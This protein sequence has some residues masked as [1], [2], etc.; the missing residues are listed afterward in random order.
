MSK[1]FRNFSAALFVIIT[2]GVIFALAGN[3]SESI[4]NESVLYDDI[5]AIERW[6][7]YGILPRVGAHNFDRN[8]TYYGF[9]DIMRRLLAYQIDEK[10][11][12]NSGLLYIRY[13][14]A[15]EIL[16]GAMGRDFNL[17]HNPLHFLSFRQ[18][19][20]ML[21]DMVQ[22]FKTN[23]FNLNLADI[24]LEN[25]LVIN[26]LHS[27]PYVL[28]SVLAN[29]S[30]SGD[31]VIVPRY[32]SHI[33][34]SNIGIEGNIV[35]IRGEYGPLSISLHNSAANALY[36][37]A[38]AEITLMGSNQIENIKVFAPADIDS[39]ALARGAILPNIYINIADAKLSGRFN[40]VEIN[41]DH[42]YAPI[43]LSA[44]GHIENLRS[45]GE[46]ILIGDV[47]VAAYNAPSLN[48]INSYGFYR[49]AE[50]SQAVE[51][52]VETA[53]SYF[54]QDLLS[55]LE[56]IVM[57]HTGVR[58]PPFVPQPTPPITIP[59]P[60]TPPMTIPPEDPPPAPEQ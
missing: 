34:L 35:I 45:T 41:L 32:A 10:F 55:Q 1:V 38:P 57:Q 12:F 25:T 48:I 40:N 17:E 31:I 21:D 36:I 39:T 52:G 58:P 56:E 19:S 50:I 22:L 59:P 18:L 23:E 15:K 46:I 5:S 2:M 20:V 26:H 6:M 37:L 4:S 7:D 3:R 42:A 27:P 29:V 9:S 24:Y 14:E 44:R 43:L 49:Q 8:I 54:A 53:M 47:Q 13:Y 28:D 16:Y 11:T 30:G 60:T 51:A 33:L